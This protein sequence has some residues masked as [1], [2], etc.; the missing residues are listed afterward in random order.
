MKNFPTG[1]RG[2]LFDGAAWGAYTRRSEVRDIR[3]VWLVGSWRKV[4]VGLVFGCRVGI[5]AVEV[6]DDDIGDVGGAP[7]VEEGGDLGAGLAIFLENEV[8]FP[9]DGNLVDDDLDVGL[10]FAGHRDE[11]LVHLLLL[12]FHELLGVPLKGPQFVRFHL[13][14][15]EKLFALFFAEGCVADFV[16][17]VAELFLGCG[18]DREALVVF[19]V[20]LCDGEFLVGRFGG[21]VFVEGTLGINDCHFGFLRGGGKNKEREE[22]RSGLEGAESHR[23]RRVML[24]ICIS[25][26]PLR[27][28]WPN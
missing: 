15:F 19:E 13:G 8:K 7:G 21:V 5:G 16:A 11:Q 10:E 14:L 1:N 9:G 12:G 18:D 20:E 28:R 23:I 26:M 22:D 25:K 2:K 24:T 6:L 17:E 4:G 27:C 3:E